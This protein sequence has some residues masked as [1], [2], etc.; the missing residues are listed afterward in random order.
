MDRIRLLDEPLLREFE[1]VLRAQPGSVLQRMRPG[2][3]EDEILTAFVAAEVATT[4]EAIRWWGWRDGSDVEV[5]PGLGHISLTNA[6]EGLEILR[7]QAVVAATTAS[8]AR[9][10]DPD[11]WWKQSWVPIFDTGGQPKTAIDC[12]GACDE[13]SPL[14]WVDWP[15]MAADDPPRVFAPS[16]GDYIARA[17]RAID[18]GRYR[19][20]P[21]RNSW[22]PMDWARLPVDDRV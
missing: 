21:D 16:L 19:F 17:V 22:M 7:G 9:I 5:L 15:A 13:P 11:A 14:L 20:D 3:S 12:S 10:S 1:R 6:L 4:R 8:I 18:A 2:L